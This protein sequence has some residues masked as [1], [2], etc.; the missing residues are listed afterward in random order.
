M[1]C[2]AFEVFLQQNIPISNFPSDQ[3]INEIIKNIMS[4]GRVLQSRDQKVMM[5]T[6]L[7]KEIWR[8]QENL[9]KEIFMRVKTQYALSSKAEISVS[10]DDCYQMTRI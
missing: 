6:Q 9:L 8:L 7:K 5:I 4:R 10:F 2:P 3:I 1:V